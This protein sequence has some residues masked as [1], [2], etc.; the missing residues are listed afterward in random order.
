[1]VKFLNSFTHKSKLCC[2]WRN[3]RPRTIRRK[4]TYCVLSTINAEESTMNQVKGLT[5]SRDNHICGSRDDVDFSS[6]S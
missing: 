3:F 1:M 4:F 6:I 5:I 2:N